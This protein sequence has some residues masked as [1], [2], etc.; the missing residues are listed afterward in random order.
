M[1]KNHSKKIAAKG[2][3]ADSEGIHPKSDAAE[4]AIEL[5]N[6]SKATCITVKNNEL[7]T[8]ASAQGIAYLID[9]YEKDMLKDVFLADKIIGKAAAIILTLG[10]VK[11]CYGY[12]VSESA[13]NWLDKHNIP[14]TYKTTTPVI[15]NRKGDGM[16]PMEATVKNIDNPEEALVA[17]KN[18]VAELRN[19][20]K[21]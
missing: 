6:N 18:K 9:L 21:V 5:I 12:T 1:K 15:Q 10:G 17:L 7:A 11:S 16:C 14:V 3:M 20:L 4:E 8:V 19:T 2:L 13:L